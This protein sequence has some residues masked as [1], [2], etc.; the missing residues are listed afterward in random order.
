MLNCNCGIFLQS[1]EMNSLEI[2][3]LVETHWLK[4]VY[5]YFLSI[6]IQRAFLPSY[7]HIVPHCVSI[8]KENGTCF[9]KLITTILLTTIADSS[10]TICDPATF[11]FL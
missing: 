1:E 5:G 10:F 4:S 9:L 8:I 3:H 11:F 2:V 7:L 6:Q